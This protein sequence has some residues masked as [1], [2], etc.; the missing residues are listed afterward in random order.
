MPVRLL[1]LLCF[2]C[3][4]STFARAEAPVAFTWIYRDAR[5]GGDYLVLRG[6]YDN[7][8][9]VC[10]SL[11]IP[12]GPAAR[13]VPIEARR[14]PIDPARTAGLRRF[15]RQ[16]D[17]RRLADAYLDA[18]RLSE[19]R[20]SWLRLRWGA[21]DLDARAIYLEYAPDARLPIP[22]AE[23]DRWSALRN[24]LE[25]AFPAAGEA[26]PWDQTAA[27]A[28]T[29]LLAAVD[30]PGAPEG[31]RALV[32]IAWAAHRAAFA[33]PDRDLGDD[34]LAAAGAP[35]RAAVARALADSGTP[36]AG[37]VDRLAA[38][39]DHADPQ[40]AVQGAEQAATWLA[41]ARELGPVLDRWVERVQQG[42]G[43]ATDLPQILRVL[44]ALAP[45]KALRTAL[46][47][48]HPDAADDLRAA[49]RQALDELAKT[50][51][52]GLCADLIALLADAEIGVRSLAAQALLDRHA[53]A[54]LDAVAPA[55]AQTEPWVRVHAAG[56]LAAIDDVA[57]TTALIALVADDKPECAVAAARALLT[58][59]RRLP[60]GPT[61][62]AL[63]PRAL[64]RLDQ[65][66]AW[67]ALAGRCVDDAG[68][69]AI[70]QV[71][72][73]HRS[74]AARAWWRATRDSLWWR[75][76]PGVFETSAR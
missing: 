49:G 68:L 36:G 19:A 59:P 70:L 33:G 44:R 40:V 14:A 15:L 10:E 39:L 56:A 46:A 66:P 55:L 60:Y 52:D 28:R 34:W 17:P 72:G 9:D 3:A 73:A 65:D 11:R 18:P 57:A 29:R 2:A 64:I 58:P 38:Q 47:A 71:P 4:A 32:A 51:P 22:G 35:V 20:A 74:A 37:V 21:G 25:Q 42:G 1:L 7:A 12:L 45:D 8:P 63:V 76:D 31:I 41:Q 23:S 13:L 67:A 62:D 54:S 24:A 48:T 43:R 26:L 5:A 6:V 69:R 61:R 50:A 53:A 75:A 27:L 30:D 16:A